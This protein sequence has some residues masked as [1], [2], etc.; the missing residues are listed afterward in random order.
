MTQYYKNSEKK[1]LQ[2]PVI[3]EGKCVDITLFVM[4]NLCF[5]D[6]ALSK[7]SKWP[8]GSRENAVWHDICKLVWC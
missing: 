8:T 1:P 2:Q 7:L 5:I 3:R 4:Y 6:Y